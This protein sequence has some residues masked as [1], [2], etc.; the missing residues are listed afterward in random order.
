MSSI[1]YSTTGYSKNDLYRLG[2][3]VDDH[4]DAGSFASD[5]DEFTPTHISMD[6]I[7]PSL[8][9]VSLELLEHES[10]RV[11]STKIIDLYHLLSVQLPEV[12][13]DSD[14]KGSYGTFGTTDASMP[15]VEHSLVDSNP[16]LNT[17]TSVATLTSLAS[18]GRQFSFAR[19]FSTQTCQ[20]SVPWRNLVTLSYIDVS[21][22]TRWSVKRLTLEVETEDVANE[23]CIN[24]NVCLSALKQRPHRLLA[25]VNPL[26]GKGKEKGMLTGLHG[27]IMFA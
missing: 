14:P 25:F 5:I 7:V 24:L 17:S 20:E 4:G 6:Q 1:L 22:A 12:T 11:I 27:C 16:T 19:L 15:V 13:D 21:N 26:C 10:E 8:T 3:C 2:I 23:V 18:A 9:H